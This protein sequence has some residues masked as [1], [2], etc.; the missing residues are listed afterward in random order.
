M[1]YLRHYAYTLAILTACFLTAISANAQRKG[2][3]NSLRV[4]KEEFF[5]TAEARRIGDQMLLYQRVTGGWPKNIDMVS[6][7]SEEDKERVMKDKSRTD[8][9]TIDNSA[10]T[11]QMTFLAQ[12][13]RQTNDQRYRE[14][15]QEGVAYLLSGQYDNG[16]WPQFW[17][18]PQGYQVH[19][20]YNDGAIT[21]TLA[22]FS[23]I[24]GEQ[25]PY[26]CDLIDA[27]TKTR[28]QQSFDKAIECILATQ[29]IVD[30]EPTVWC[31]QHDRV[32]LQPAKA[33]SY[34]LPSFCSQ[35]SARIVELLMTLPAPS[36]EVK[37]AV[38]GAMRWFEKYKLTG[39][40]YDRVYILGSDRLA[41]LVPD[42]NAGPLWARYYDLE[43]CEPYV[44]DRDGVPR[45]RLADLGAERRN[46]YSWYGTR[47]VELYRLYPQ[48][49]DTHDAANKVSIS[50]TT[51]GA[52]ENG[53][54]KTKVE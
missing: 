32:T 11:T 23:S 41:T 37:R 51:K 45:H 47:P 35:E 34:E 12:L 5:K 42:P 4:N 26:D 24:I 44:C 54:L 20:T 46:G 36:P 17:P 2:G 52:N 29:I 27:A 7:M 25:N 53:T 33:R 19:I 30:G 1:S 48:W 38:H 40:R 10:T 22:L 16:G 18:N 3:R 9:S 43:N 31:Q 49:A 6:R 21:N 13:Y 15:F 8:D 14:A 39:L 50:L 28:L